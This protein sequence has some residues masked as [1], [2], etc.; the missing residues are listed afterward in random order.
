MYAE[1]RESDSLDILFDLPLFCGNHK[2]CDMKD[3]YRIYL[4][5]QSHYHSSFFPHLL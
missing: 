5:I 1:D 3:N 4:E 2:L